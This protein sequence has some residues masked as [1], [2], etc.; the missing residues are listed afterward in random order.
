MQARGSATVRAKSWTCTTER[1]FWAYQHNDVC[2]CNC[3]SGNS[4]KTDCLDCI[5]DMQGLF[6]IPMKRS[7]N[8]C[9]NGVVA[10]L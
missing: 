5:F 10:F 1:G 9:D 6:D 4:E 2:L 3:V 8:T 7:I